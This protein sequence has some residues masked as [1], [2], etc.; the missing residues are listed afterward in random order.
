MGRPPSIQWYY[1]QWLGDNKVLA[2]DWDARAMHFHLLMLSIQEN[3]PGTIPADDAA[4]RRWLNLPLNSVESDQI[5]RRVKPQVLA[6]WQPEGDRLGNTGMLAAVERQTKYR[7]R[8]ENG[9]RNTANFNE[10]EIR[11]KG[12]DVEVPKSNTKAEI[13]TSD[14]A[15]HFVLVELGLGGKELR[16]AIHE[17]IHR[18]L[19]KLGIAT[20]DTAETM[21]DSYR[22]YLAAEV[23]FRKGPLKF[24]TEGIWR[25]NPDEWRSH[26]K[27]GQAS[28][29]QRRVDNTRGNLINTV[30]KRAAERAGHSSGEQQNGTDGELERRTDAA[31]RG[32]ATGSN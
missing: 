29:A 11:S 28:T 25:Q 26:G 2:M 22:L 5:W 17:Q 24:F 27:S 31:V 30:R 21:V 14:D 19:E 3:P 6:A 18:Q 12:F 20:K 13:L 8:Y 7:N 15:A 1:K 16:Y 10:D 4:I 23:E 32:T 9:T